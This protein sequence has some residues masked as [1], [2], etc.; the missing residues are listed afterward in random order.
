MTFSVQIIS[1]R[2]KWKL[3]AIHPR[4]WDTRQLIGSNRA[5]KMSPLSLLFSVN[6]ATTIRPFP[7]ISLTS[8]CHA[9]IHL[10]HFPLGR[11]DDDVVSRV[12]NRN[13]SCMFVGVLQGNEFRDDLRWSP[14][15]SGEDV[16]RG[17]EGFTIDVKIRFKNTAMTSSSRFHLATAEG[18]LRNTA[19][20]KDS[21]ISY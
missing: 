16:P 2:A 9:E 7:G 8:T 3:G 15:I 11:R 20:M 21:R 6:T 13:Y 14:G 10:L 18:M 17:G 4:E 1:T 19:G 12:I 5:R